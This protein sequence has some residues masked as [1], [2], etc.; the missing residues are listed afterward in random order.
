MGDMT[1]E[2]LLPE[3]SDAI[4]AETRINVWWCAYSMERFQAAATL[5]NSAFEDEDI[6]VVLPLKQFDYDA[7]VSNH[8]HC[9]TYT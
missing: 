5:Y 8:S 7:G 3:P 1:A 6:T 9:R 2:S 4:E